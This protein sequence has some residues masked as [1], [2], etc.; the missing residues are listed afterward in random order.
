MSLNMLSNF[1]QVLNSRKKHHTK[2]G[3]F[4][5]HIIFTTIYSFKEPKL[6]QNKYSEQELNMTNFSQA[7]ANDVHMYAIFKDFNFYVFL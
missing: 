7:T 6:N 2:N 3:Y 5:M 1:M 4:P